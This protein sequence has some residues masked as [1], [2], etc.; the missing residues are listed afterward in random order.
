MIVRRSD[1]LARLNAELPRAAAKRF[2]WNRS[3]LDCC[4]FAA[5]LVRAMTGVNVMAGFSYTT[6]EAAWAQIAERGG[7]RPFLRETFGPSRRP[8]FAQRGDIMLARGGKAV[9][10]CIG[11][12]VAMMSEEVGYVTLP[13]SEFMAAFPLGWPE[14]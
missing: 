3:G 10:I 6:E 5:R 11:A 9:G 2:A 13:L 4:R 8:A 7:L 1:W 14:A 12:R